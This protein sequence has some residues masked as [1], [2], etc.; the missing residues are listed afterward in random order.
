MI[1]YIEGSPATLSLLIFLGLKYTH[2][3]THTHKER[4]RSHQS[5]NNILLRRPF[6]AHSHKSPRQSHHPHCQH[7]IIQTHT[8]VHVP[9]S[10]HSFLY[11]IQSILLSSHKRM[12]S[13]RRNMSRI[14]TQNSPPN[15]HITCIDFFWLCLKH[16]SVQQQL[17]VP[18]CPVPL[19][20]PFLSDRVRV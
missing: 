6:T 2:R 14:L 7:V 10:M 16:T 9:H 17:C 15:T 13:K 12:S 11:S 3:H 18:L 8:Q 20:R 1:D 19:H 4:G 5:G